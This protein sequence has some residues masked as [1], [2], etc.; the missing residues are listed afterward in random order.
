MPRKLQ[1]EFIS[2]NAAVI[3]RNARQG[4]NDPPLRIARGR[5]DHKP[6]YAH[7]VVVHGDC[8]LVYDPAAKILSCGARLV[9]QAEPG[10]VE[11][12]R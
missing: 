2:V 11:I 12:T 1:P 10:A 5:N 4:T 3:G 7:E 6:R 8:K 9:L